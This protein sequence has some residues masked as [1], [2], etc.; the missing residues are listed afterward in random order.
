MV[1]GERH[2]KGLAVQD[3]TLQANH[4]YLVY[5]KSIRNE[6][7]MWNTEGSGART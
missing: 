7:E 1:K 3:M 4:T 6:R 5:F 2:K